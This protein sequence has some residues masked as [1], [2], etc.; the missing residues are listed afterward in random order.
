MQGGKR[1]GGE[2][3]GEEG[4]GKDGRGE[5]EGGRRAC[6]VSTITAHATACC[7]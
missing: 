3:K 7:T 6:E 1:G 5:E 4:E 2:G